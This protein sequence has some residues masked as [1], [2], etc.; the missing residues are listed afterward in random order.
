MKTV[1]KII[2]IILVAVLSLLLL[3]NVIALFSKEI[4]KNPFPS[5]FGYSLVSINEGSGSMA[6]TLMPK[7]YFIIKK[8][9]G[10]EVG[11]IITYQDK[12][13]VVTHRIIAQ[14]LDGSY[15]TKGDANVSADNSPVATADIYGKIVA[16]PWGL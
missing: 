6:P 10:Y 13:M 11:D 7:D 15:Q 1:G 5:I 3:F 2:N 12:T 14:N 16:M 9:K 8:Q 4:L